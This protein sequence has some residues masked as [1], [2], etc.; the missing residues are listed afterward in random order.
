MRSELI[1]ALSLF[2]F[3]SLSR[4]DHIVANA[5]QWSAFFASR[6]AGQSAQQAILNG[7]Q[8]LADC[9]VSRSTSSFGILGMTFPFLSFMSA[10]E[11][12]RSEHGQEEALL[13]L[14][15]IWIL[16]AKSIGSVMVIP[17]WEYILDF[18]RRPVTVSC[19][20]KIL[21]ILLSANPPLCLRGGV[22]KNEYSSERR[23]PFSPKESGE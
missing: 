13:I 6:F 22:P 8:V 9:R 10:R 7:N 16:N 17:P 15:S 2:S 18:S 20:S 21:F 1:K 14:S 12:D 23:G 4:R 3:L 5:F 11:I 19:D